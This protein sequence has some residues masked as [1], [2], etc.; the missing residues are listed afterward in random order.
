[1]PIYL[2]S[3]YA[4]LRQT[5]CPP[6][7]IKPLWSQPLSDSCQVFADI[8][9]D[10]QA[11]GLGDKLFTYR[12][13][14][15]LKD[16]TFI[17][18]QVLV[19]FGPQQ[20]GG[21]VVGLKERVESDAV[22]IKDI[23]EIL[24]PD[25]LYD[26]NYI[27]FLY[28]IAEFYGSTL[29][30]VI[31][32]AVPADFSM[33]LKRRVELRVLGE[34]DQGF[35]YQTSNYAQAQILNAL[36]QAKSKSLSLS[37]LKQ[38]A[39]IKGGDFYKALTALRNAEQINI[40]TEQTNST[41]AK[42]VNC[43]IW[44]GSEPVGA[45][46]KEIIACIQQ[47]GGIISTSQL[48]EKA[49][50]TYATINKMCAQGILSTAQQEVVRDSL[51]KH[52][53]Y[54]E[55]NGGDARPSLT[56]HQARVLRVLSEDLKETIKQDYAES[57][58][59][60]LLHGVTGSGKTEIYLRLIE[61]TLQMGRTALLLVPEISLTPQLAKRLKNR[62]GS[63]VAIW[64]SALSQGERFDTWRRLRAG[65]VK[66]LLGARSAILVNMPDLGLIICDEEH[67]GSY[68]QSSPA[69]RYHAKT[70]AME[71]AR[72]LSCLVL[73]GS[74]TPDCQ[75]Y[76][77]A[78][79][80]KRILELPER[81]FKQEMPEV[82]IVDMRDEFAEG[83]RSI[84]SRLLLHALEKRLAAKEQVILLMNR[85][86]YA[87]HIFCRA[88]G[89]VMKC[90]NCSVCLVYHQPSWS[91]E[92]RPAQTNLP[93]TKKLGYYRC[94]H[95]NFTTG[96][97]H[98]CPACESPYLKHFGLGTQKVEEDV[99]E[100]FPD[101]RVLRLDS[102][103]TSRRGA[104]ETVLKDFAA[105]LADILIGTQM[106]AKGLDIHGV[107]LV[108]VL[109]ADSAF[110][111][112]DYRTMERGFQLLTQVAGRAG[113]GDKPGSVILQTYNPEIPAL[114]LAQKHDYPNFYA[115]EIQGRQELQ[116]PPFAQLI[117]LV[118]SGEDQ[119]VVESFSDRL[120]ES[121]ANLLENQTSESTISILGPA[122]CLIEKLQ[123]KTRYQIII[124]NL[125]GDQSRQ[126]IVSY[127][128]HLPIKEPVRLALDVDPLDFA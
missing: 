38:K 69:P 59:P 90:R 3:S 94:H 61:E 16:Q 9:V 47:A 28:W 71:K 106:I 10:I 52:E 51:T 6:A 37:A 105:G 39:K 84:F 104:F 93:S 64:H 70:L 125:A 14:G 18:S 46:Q 34:R 118:I 126:T 128:R 42:V 25:P 44:T 45:R 48:V 31:Q 86:G 65:D 98:I 116:Y 81:V 17:G 1:M 41:Q 111:L 66:V 23:L 103:V 72:R 87:N 49:G 122:P 85:R 73:L 109:S 15:F 22:S 8:V 113:R 21:Y 99:R 56:D 12:I 115:G 36:K 63:Q 20:V 24:E 123:G 50:T 30:Q 4:T 107:T 124:K 43:V 7:N 68:K 75:T 76:F 53:Y 102:D 89:H 83:N 95:C 40:Y 117:R 26:R 2:R 78:E 54:Q 67:D 108:G 119:E 79:K 91:P 62:F 11:Q 19:P 5:Y 114:S 121:L 32:A 112:P 58:S 110:N 57:V 74:A 97:T 35:G 120:A 96:E 127:I 77:Q 27:D 92:A 33:R 100:L 29:S 88:C 60:W 82:K 13:P 101:A 80:D 55:E